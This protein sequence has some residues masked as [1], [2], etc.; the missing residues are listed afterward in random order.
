MNWAQMQPLVQCLMLLPSE[1]L[2]SVRLRGARGALTEALPLGASQ[3]QGVRLSMR[4]SLNVH[5]HLWLRRGLAMA[6]QGRILVT[7]EGL[8][9][10]ADL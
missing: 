10:K 7:A 2:G 1:H 8:L 4:A 3:V 6:G 9:R 5:E